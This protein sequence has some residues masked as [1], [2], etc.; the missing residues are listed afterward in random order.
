MTSFRM[1][2]SALIVLGTVLTLGVIGAL[3]VFEILEMLTGIP[4]FVVV[5]IVGLGIPAYRES[6]L[7]NKLFQEG[8][9]SKSEM[10]ATEKKRD[11]ISGWW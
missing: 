7:E 1:V 8:K 5:G 4:L 2:S 3:T 6:R 10:R 9:I 11:L